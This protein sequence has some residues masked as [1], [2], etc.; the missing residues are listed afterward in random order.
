MGLDDEVMGESGPGGHDLRIRDGQG[1]LV[2]F[3]LFQPGSV[4]EETINIESVTVPFQFVRN[5]DGSS[6][7]TLIWE[8]KDWIPNGIGLGTFNFGF[9]QEFKVYGVDEKGVSKLICRGIDYQ[10]DFKNRLKSTIPMEQG[11]F[12]QYRI[13]FEPVSPQIRAN[14]DLLRALNKRVEESSFR[15][16]IEEFSLENVNLVLTEII[17]K[18]HVHS[19]QHSPWKSTVDRSSPGVTAFEFETRGEPLRGIV[20]KFEKGIFQVRAELD[21]WNSNY[22]P[23]AWNTFGMAH[24][25]HLGIKEFAGDRQA[26]VL[27]TPDMK[28]SSRKFR[29]R[30][31]HEDNPSFKVEG[32]ELLTYAVDLFFIRDGEQSYTLE[33]GD[34]NPP[35]GNRDHPNLIELVQNEAKFTEATLGVPVPIS[36]ARNANPFE[37]WLIRMKDFIPSWGNDLVASLGPWL[38]CILVALGGGLVFVVFLLILFLRMLKKDAPINE[39]ETPAHW[40][41][42][43]KS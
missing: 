39:A 28:F 3:I 22:D 13:R 11:K 1:K 32:I 26:M 15:Q 9:E 37:N 34:P 24:L 4:V 12:Q 6:E 41:E 19:R 10:D 7:A 43:S 38:T 29:F 31:H 42:E 5:P 18:R 33:Y 17:S 23:P 27:E 8:E 40:M 20:P 30:I 21:F 16:P 14:L 35:T 2:P 36:S 25:R